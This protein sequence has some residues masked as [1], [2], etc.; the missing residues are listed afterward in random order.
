MM[1]TVLVVI[2]ALLTGA[3]TWHLIRRYKSRI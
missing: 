2:G 3:C 1:V